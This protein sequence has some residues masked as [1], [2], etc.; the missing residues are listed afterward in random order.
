MA[1]FLIDICMSPEYQTNIANQY[2]KLLMYTQNTS[3]GKTYKLIG[4]IKNI[5]HLVISCVVILVIHGSL[6]L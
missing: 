4:F 3:N 5:S 6:N 2:I 1:T